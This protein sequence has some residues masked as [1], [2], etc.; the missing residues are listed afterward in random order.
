M[1]YASAWRTPFKFLGKS[2]IDRSTGTSVQP[3]TQ[4]PDP[5]SVEQISNLAV[6]S[7]SCQ[8]GQEPQGHGYTQSTT[9]A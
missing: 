1:F 5:V 8:R 6:P 9:I 2:L 3:R 4:L 7:L